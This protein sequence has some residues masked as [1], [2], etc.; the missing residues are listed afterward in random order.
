MLIVTCRARRF[1]AISKRRSRRSIMRRSS[2][3]SSARCVDRVECGKVLVQRTEASLDAR[4]PKA[5]LAL[6]IVEFGMKPPHLLSGVFDMFGR[7][8]KPFDLAR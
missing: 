5:H 2:E 3:I 7:C 4:K 8:W 6:N 1:Y